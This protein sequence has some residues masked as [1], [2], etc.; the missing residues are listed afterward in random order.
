MQLIISSGGEI[1][2]LYDET[3]PLTEFG[4]LAIARGSHVEPTAAGEWTADLAPV[5][6]PTLG[7]FTTR[8]QALLAEQQWLTEHWLPASSA[9]HPNL[10]ES[11]QPMMTAT[12]GCAVNSSGVPT[13]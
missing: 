13:M 7:P 12:I 2:C 11:D 9:L 8:S 1:R 3:L 4:R 5:A 6:G 10:I